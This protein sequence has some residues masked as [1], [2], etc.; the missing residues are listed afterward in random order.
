M[1][2]SP[3]MVVALI[4]LF[5]SATGVTWAAS[6]LPADSVKSKQILNGGVKNKDLAPDSV[7]GDNVVDESLGASDLAFDT[8]TA[9][10]LADGSV[11][12]FAIQSDAVGA[13]Q[14]VDDSVGV[15]ELMNDS[16]GRDELGELAVG[17]A[18]LGEL[19]TRPGDPVPVPGGTGENASYRVETATAACAEG[20]R[21]ISGFATWDPDD[22]AENDYELFIAETVVDP[23][24]NTVTVEG[25]N[26]SGVDHSLIAVAVCLLP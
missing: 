25:G 23:L 2:P 21:L 11:D 4:A 19:T 26:D 10:Q 8:I 9:D 13:D 24:A 17:A 14:I 7:T 22:A 5:V 1:K 6:K 20:E 18:E 12:G 16:V 15:D 3:A